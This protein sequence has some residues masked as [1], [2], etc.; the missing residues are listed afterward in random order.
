[1]SLPEKKLPTVGLNNGGYSAQ[2]VQPV[3][4]GGLDR[5]FDGLSRMAEAFRRTQEAEDVSRLIN[6]GLREAQKL[7]N[8]YYNLK[9][10]DKANDFSFDD[11]STQIAALREK[12]AAMAKTQKGG[13]R[14]FNALDGHYTN[15][16]GKVHAHYLES[17]NALHSSR[18]EAQ[19]ASYVDM[20]K[21][22][23]PTQWAVGASGVIALAQ[24]DSA[25]LNHTPEQAEAHKKEVVQKFIE[26]GVEAWI[27][28]GDHKA[29]L[30]FLRF[31]QSHLGDLFGHANDEPPVEPKGENEEADASASQDKGTQKAKRNNV[32]GDEE[33]EKLEVYAGFFGDLFHQVDKLRARETAFEIIQGMNKEFGLGP[34][35]L[36]TMATTGKGKYFDVYEK[37]LKDAGLKVE[38]GLIAA[39]RYYDGI[40]KIR[41]ARAKTE[42]AP[43]FAMYYV[44]KL[45]WSSKGSTGESPEEIHGRLKRA[46]DKGDHIAAAVANDIW[47][48]WHPPAKGGDGSIPTQEQFVEYAKIVEAFASDPDSAAQIYNRQKIC[49]L[50]ALG[51]LNHGLAMKA[52]SFLGDGLGAAQARRLAPS[53]FEEQVNLL[54][55]GRF[56]E[57]SKK[58]SIL[59]EKHKKQAVQEISA[60]FATGGN[61]N[62]LPVT[63]NAIARKHLSPALTA[64]NKDR[65]SSFFH[66][67]GWGAVK[68]KLDKGVYFAQMDA[69]YENFD[70]R[71]FFDNKKL[72]DIR[73]I[74]ATLTMQ[75]FDPAFA[76]AVA[77]QAIKL[78]VSPESFDELENVAKQAIQSDFV[79]EENKKDDD[80]VVISK[81]MADPEFKAFLAERGWSLER[82]NSASESELKPL[83]EGLRKHLFDKQ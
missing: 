76:S 30:K 64:I 7:Q 49:E 61:K 79:S 16:F 51:K 72:R 80:N 1:M 15:I 81:A 67:L 45:G 47:Q 17:K 14:V 65:H 31:A 83:A 2:R 13:D 40:Q 3:D 52:L 74:Q 38:D 8:D 69:L 36:M 50:R 78:K 63:V 55:N 24:N 70:R 19:F 11:F 73:D 42:F 56:G 18:N 33:G 12:Y 32:G 21:N 27:R 60:K 75:G 4:Y 10:T 25:F 35:A 44:E 59:L 20:A 39:Q 5:G 23:D 37:R 28:K 29:A 22:S 57:L 6:E 34:Q 66:W 77:S 48:L 71:W 68:A 26:G 43:I 53:G 9:G 62:L 41:D 46:G 82:F 58:E 54:F